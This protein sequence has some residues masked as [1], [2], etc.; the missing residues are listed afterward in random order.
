MRGKPMFVRPANWDWEKYGR[1]LT[2]GVRRIDRLS[3]RLQGEAEPRIRFFLKRA[4]DEVVEAARL[5]AGAVASND[6]VQ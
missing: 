5:A 1:N 3:A 2:E 6:H 4:I